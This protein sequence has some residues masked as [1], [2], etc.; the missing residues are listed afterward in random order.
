MSKDKKEYR[1]KSPIKHDGKRYG[2]GDSILLTDEQAELLHVG[3]GDESETT[4][5]APE[6]TASPSMALN[7][8]SAINVIENADV[9]EVKEFV[10]PESVGGTEDRK[11]VLK[12]YNEKLAEAAES[13]KE[14]K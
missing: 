10:I 11:T 4:P 7:A 13:S 12:A 8:K 2:V 9:D 3:S 14:E 1:V 6:I 5:D